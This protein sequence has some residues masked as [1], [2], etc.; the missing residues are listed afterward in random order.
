MPFAEQY[1]VEPGHPHPDDDGWLEKLDVVADVAP[2]AM[3]FTFGC[4]EPA[5]LDRLRARGVLTLVTVSSAVG[6]AVAVQAGA[7]TLVVQGR[8]PAGTS[9]FDPGAEPPTAPLLGSWPRPPIS[10]FR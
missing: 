6:A 9:I 10:A 2:E 7:G 8:R 4:P 3:S 1:G 5:V